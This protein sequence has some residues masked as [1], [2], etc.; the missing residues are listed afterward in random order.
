MAANSNVP[1]DGDYF[2]AVPLETEDHAASVEVAAE[3]VLV[4]VLGPVVTV[5]LTFTRAGAREV[6]YRVIEASQRITEEAN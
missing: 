5:G 3:M 4:R 1:G 2:A 6:A